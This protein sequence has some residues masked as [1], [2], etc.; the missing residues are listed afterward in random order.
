[1]ILSGLAPCQH[2]ATDPELRRLAKILQRLQPAASA[3]MRQA[4][5]ADTA[6]ADARTFPQALHALADE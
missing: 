3:A 5:Q 2:P 4:E 6:G 1:V